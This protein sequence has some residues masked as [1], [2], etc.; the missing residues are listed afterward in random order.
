MDLRFFIPQVVYFFL[1]LMQFV[2]ERQKPNGQPLTQV[3][4]AFLLT[5]LV[6]LGGFFD[7]AL[8]AIGLMGR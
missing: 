1:I 7:G 4:A 5:V 6:A 2:A 8:I 3:V